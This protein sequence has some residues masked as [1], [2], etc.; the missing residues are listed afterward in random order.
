MAPHILRLEQ[1]T[2]LA[3]LSFPEYSKVRAEYWKKVHDA[4]N[5]YL[6]SPANDDNWFKNAMRLA[7]E[8]SFLNA[9]LTALYDGVGESELSVSLLA[10]LAAYKVAEFGFVES[11]LL[12]LRT[13]KFPGQAADEE[14]DEEEQAIWDEE[15]ARKRA[16]GY[17]Q[18][19]DILY[20]NIKVRSAGEK[21]LLFGGYDGVE[22]CFDCQ[23]YKGKKKPASWWIVND[24]VPPNRNFE[25]KGYN[26]LHVLVDPITGKIFTL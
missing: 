15:W 1:A 17:A 26:C 5:G 20:N 24:A 23:K 9:A 3:E 6:A 19:L 10:F 18:G 16:D 12:S 7:I 22:S 13:R 25:C 4:V 8:V 2:R 11:L 21:L 14:A